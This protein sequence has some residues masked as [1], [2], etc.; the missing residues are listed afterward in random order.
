MQI[1]FDNSSGTLQFVFPADE[2]REAQ[3]ILDLFGWQGD[4][5]VDEIMTLVEAWAESMEHLQ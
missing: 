3:K 5:D 1:G 2:L 4:A